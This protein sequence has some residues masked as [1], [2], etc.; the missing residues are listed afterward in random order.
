ML[1][2]ADPET[3]HNV[4]FKTLGATRRHRK[5]N[6]AAKTVSPK[7]LLA[8]AHPRDKKPFQFLWCVTRPARVNLSLMSPAISDKGILGAFGLNVHIS[9]V[10]P[11]KSRH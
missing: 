6:A 11:S 8:D 4:A 2:A 5:G 10:T 3:E 9:D 1:A 7:R